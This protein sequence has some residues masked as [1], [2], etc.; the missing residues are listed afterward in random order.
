MSLFF[1]LPLKDINHS[2]FNSVNKELLEN[3]V[4]KKFIEHLGI[5]EPSMINQ[6]YNIILPQYNNQREFDTDSHFKVFFNYYCNSSSHKVS[7]FINIIN[8]YEFIKYHLKNDKQVYYGSGKSMYFPTYEN[9]EFFSP[10]EKAQFVALE[11]YIN[12]IGEENN[13]YLESFFL[14]L[15]V[16]K[17]ID[18]QEVEIDYETSERT[19]LPKVRSTRVVKYT[20]RRIEGCADLI[21]HI[22]ENQDKEKSILLWNTLNRVIETKCMDWGTRSL[23]SL[24]TGTCSYFY[25]H[26]RLENFELSDAIILKNNK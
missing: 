10:D 24:L 16:K 21:K 26:S 14:K 11:Y 7:E 18:V 25:R 15:G 8:D 12:L 6:I 22:V 1:F 23:S 4:T 13:R 19:D 9:K 2:Q 17:E 20:E 5:K 3:E